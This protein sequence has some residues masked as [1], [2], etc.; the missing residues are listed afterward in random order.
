V[1]K[2]PGPQGHG[3]AVRLVSASKN[4]ALARYFS[5]PV[6]SLE[7][8]FFDG[9]NNEY[10][11]LPVH[12]LAIPTEG[13]PPVWRLTLADGSMWIFR[14]GKEGTLERALY[15]TSRHLRLNVV[16][17]TVEVTFQGHAGSLQRMTSKAPAPENELR[18]I[19]WIG[20]NGRAH[21]ADWDSIVRGAVLHYVAN[22][23]DGT[24]HNVTEALRGRKRKTR[25]FDGG[26]AFTSLQA[27]NSDLMKAVI[28]GLRRGRPPRFSTAL[29]RDLS[30]VNIAAWE[31]DLTRALTGVASRDIQGTINRLERV[32]RDGLA[33]LFSEL[34]RVP[35]YEH[36]FVSQ[37]F[38]RA[39]T[40][41]T[42]AS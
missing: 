36:G 31:K 41:G 27:S 24:D 16:E 8:S 33:A 18:G 9:K 40:K 22:V 25:V 3:L 14:S 20:L 21:R 1:K 23:F 30:G 19:G 28:A 12:E 32:Q 26:E 35:V 34:E 37:L 11:W 4:R 38:A 2:A 15:L 29:K 5:Q 6:V 10:A 7:R 17:K 13:K 42:G 39:P